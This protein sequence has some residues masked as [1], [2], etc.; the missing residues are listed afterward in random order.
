MLSFLTVTQKDFLCSL[1][2]K[3]LLYSGQT[4]SEFEANQVFPGCLPIFTWGSFLSKAYF[5]SILFTNTFPTGLLL[6]SPPTDCW[7]GLDT[8]NSYWNLCKDLVWL[9]DSMYICF[10]VVYFTFK[11]KVAIFYLKKWVSK[12][13]IFN[14]GERCVGEIFCT[15]T[16]VS[17]IFQ[18]DST[19]VVADPALGLLSYQQGL[20]PCTALQ[21]WF[22]PVPAGPYW[23]LTPLLHSNWT[24]PLPHQSLNILNIFSVY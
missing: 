11:R 20:H 4:G 9:S 3:W 21:S 10:Q 17:S 7:R 24:V 15:R 2:R 22:S 12:D 23:W 19:F 5:P 13:G 14:I 18:N 8:N 6:K 1:F 16:P